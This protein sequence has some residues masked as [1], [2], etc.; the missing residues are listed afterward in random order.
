MPVR[1]DDRRHLPPSVIPDFALS[2]PMAR[3]CHGCLEMYY[4][5]TSPIS[6]NASRGSYRQTVSIEQRKGIKNQGRVSVREERSVCLER[7]QRLQ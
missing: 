3:E 4:E 6:Q 7:S 2:S 5:R 1:E